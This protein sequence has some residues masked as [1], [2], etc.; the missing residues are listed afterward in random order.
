MR[1]LSLG[2]I[3]VFTAQLAAS[4]IGGQRSFEFLNIP[5]SARQA[6]S[7][8][9]NVSHY[10]KD[11]N[12]LFNNPA[13][14]SADL[15]GFASINYLS[16]PGGIDL[17]ALSYVHNDNK[18]GTWGLG[19]KYLGYG[20]FESFDDV[21]NSLGEFDARD[22][23][24]N[25]SHSRKVR[26]FG[27]GAS[28][29]IVSTSIASFNSSALLL[30][31]GGTF[32]HPT[33]D[34]VIGMVIENVGFVVSDFSETSES[35]VPFDVKLGVSFKPEYMPIRFTT[36]AYNL[37]EGDLAFFVSDDEG[38]ETEQPGTVDKIFRHLAV[39]MEMLLSDNF[40]LRLGYNHLLRKELR[41]EGI[42][43]GAG[44]SYGF[45]F[46]IKSFEFAYTRANYHVAAAGNTFTLTSNLNS[47]IKR[48]E[49]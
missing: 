37:Y 26:N 31:I 38:L 41:L 49:N 14:L 48:K 34:L 43:G 13:L 23:L 1:R 8:G 12:L 32:V 5:A 27:I 9:V 39:G 42:S 21:G 6:A 16:F 17:A 24:L 46:K 40:N 20:N 47:I 19:I 22:F 28:L 3:L 15:G 4:Q 35:N 33:K 45:M 11:V 2:I 30:D 7:G 25:I 44:F 29:K 18:L 10:S 36:T